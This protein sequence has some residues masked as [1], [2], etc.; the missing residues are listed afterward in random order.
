MKG[1]TV[2]TRAQARA[3]A[4]RE[5]ARLRGSPVESSPESPRQT[6]TPKPSAPK[7]EDILTEEHC[8]AF[9]ANPKKDPTTNKTLIYASARFDKIN[10]LCKE[11]FGKVAFVDRIISE[12]CNPGFIRAVCKNI[13]Q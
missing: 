11:K 2:E 13:K 7:L 3:R 6:I 8:D 4:Q 10:D 12:N 5:Q 9:L 1:G